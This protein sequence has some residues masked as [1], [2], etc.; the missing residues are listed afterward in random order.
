MELPAIT[1]QL[2]ILPKHRYEKEILGKSFVDLAIGSGPYTISKYKRNSYVLY[3]RNKKYWAKNSPFNRGRY[4]F[5]Y[6]KINYYKDENSMIEAFKKGDFDM[7]VCYNS[8]T[9]ATALQGEKFSKLRWIKKD[10]LPHKNNQGAQGF[11][12]ISENLC[13]KT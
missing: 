1:L 4:N 8:K 3:K 7:F 12:L 5:D 9:W 10:L 13:F 6:I 11:S 2:P